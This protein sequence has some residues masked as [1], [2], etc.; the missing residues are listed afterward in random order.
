MVISNKK[1]PDVLKRL[2]MRMLDRLNHVETELAFVDEEINAQN[3]LDDRCKRLIE[4]LGVGRLAASAIVA[5]VGNA[6][7]FRSGREF[8]AWLGL[9]PRQHSSGGKQNLQGMSK[10]GDAY[11]RKMLIHG[12]RA[13]IRH[14]NRNNAP[15]EWLESLMKRRHRNVVIVA[16]ANK[17]ARTAWAVL[18]REQ[19][20]IR[21]EGTTVVA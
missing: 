20:Y 11:I 18:S 14:M 15:V 7:E 2:V 9:V 10:K 6:R 3:K 19:K 8:S 16:L 1:L 21:F 17:L 4:I 12:A 5:S 13:V